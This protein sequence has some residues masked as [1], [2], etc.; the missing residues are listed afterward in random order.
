M[1]GEPERI[2]SLY[3]R[4]GK[5]TGEVAS[6]AG[7][8]QLPVVPAGVMDMLILDVVFLTNIH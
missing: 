1:T 3:E 6:L 8:R 4:A 7:T 2:S 5:S